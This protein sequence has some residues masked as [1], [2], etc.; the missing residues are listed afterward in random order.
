MRPFPDLSEQVTVSTGG[1]RSPVW[2]PNGEELFY[3]GRE[4]VM[5][6]TV[7]ES[8]DTRFDTARPLF[9]DR[10]SV[11]NRRY[12]VAPDGRRFLMVRTRDRA[13]QSSVSLHVVLNWLEELR[14]RVRVP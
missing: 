14:E 12:D 4:A 9:A 10:Y 7:H 13:P 6:V 1:G 11:G 3:R 8:G 5:A 2:A